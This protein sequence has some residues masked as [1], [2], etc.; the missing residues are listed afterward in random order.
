MKSLSVFAAA[1]LTAVVQGSPQHVDVSSEVSSFPPSLSALAGN[2]RTKSN[3][4]D[5]NEAQLEFLL[6]DLP[7]HAPANFPHLPHLPLP[8]TPFLPYGGGGLAC[9]VDLTVPRRAQAE[10]AF[11]KILPQNRMARCTPRTTP[12]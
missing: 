7:T 2:T 10:S 4:R 8:L 12:T 11:P 1:L 3:W 6:M 5:E 9:L